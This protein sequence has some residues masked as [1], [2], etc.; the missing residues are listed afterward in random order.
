MHISK[1]MVASAALASSARASMS[2][3]PREEQAFARQLQ[4]RS[5]LDTIVNDIER[6][7]TCTGCR[8]ALGL[9]KGLAFFGDGVFVDTLQGLCRTFTSEDDDVCDGSLAGE[10]PI[11]AQ[12]IRT[13]QLSGDP[14]TLF[15]A[16]FLGLC[17]YPAINEWTVPMPAKSKAK[18]TASSVATSS[19]SAPASTYTKT[20]LKIVQYSDIHVDQRYEAGSSS[21]CTKPI[22][23]HAYTPADAPGN[24]TSPAGP[25]GEHTCDSPASLEDAMYTA[26]QEFA[27]DAAFSI[28]TGDVIDHAVWETSEEYN[29]AGIDSSYGKMAS[30]MKLVYG[31]FGNHESTPPNAFEPSEYGTYAQWVYSTVAAQWERWLGSGSEQIATTE[32]MGAY[33]EL[34]PGLNLRI[35][36]LNTNVFYIQNYFLYHDPMVKDPNNQVTW[37]VSEL[38]AAETNGE[39]VYIIGH[40]PPGYPDSFRD[41]SN[42]LNQVIERYNETIAGMFYGHTHVDQWEVSYTDYNNRN[43]QTAMGMSYICPSLTPITGMPSFRIYEVDPDTY[44]I[45]DS[46]TYIANMSDPTYQD[47]KVPRFTK[48]YSARETYGPLVANPPAPGQ[49]LNAAFW[50][51]VTDVLEA[52]DEQFDAYLLRKARGWDNGQAPPDK[53][54]EICMLRAGRAQDN[55]FVPTPGLR[56][57]KHN[58]DAHGHEDCGVSLARSMLSGV[59]SD[60]SA[61]QY[62]QDTYTNL[63]NGNATA[64]AIRTNIT[65]QVGN[66][67]TT[68]G[69]N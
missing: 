23:C 57:Q 32:S 55:C 41:Q 30:A 58:L 38:A 62:L 21:E 42:Y 67:S 19:A 17:D 3:F 15:C 13:M 12:S 49:P 29:K 45:L 7:A 56:L 64:S 16:S 9:L 35:I 44:Q 31:T 26:I 47:Q 48:Y 51:E 2:H 68:T 46:I 53:A 63:V 34:V 66:L 18:R 40:T 65:E 28:F 1:F 5:L 37:L 61:L 20:P 11:M 22:C 24:S 14:A 6:D 52:S 60:R 33:S 43:A 54:S 25:N 4:D 59:F 36:S 10:G 27:S 69:R 50:H 8:A 39:K